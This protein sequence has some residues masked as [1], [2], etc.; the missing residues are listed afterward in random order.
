MAD[1]YRAAQAHGRRR[2]EVACIF[3]AGDV[4]REAVVFTLFNKIAEEKMRFQVAAVAA[5]VDVTAGAEMGIDGLG[6]EGVQRLAGNGDIAVIG[7]GQLF[8]E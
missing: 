3:P 8:P 7:I 2:G 1:E 5:A 4:K 6:I